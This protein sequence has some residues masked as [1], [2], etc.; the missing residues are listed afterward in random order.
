MSFDNHFVWG[1]AAASYQIE[2]AGE[3]AGRGDS[4]WDMFSRQ[5]D[6]V[7][8]NQSGAVACDHYHRYAEDVRLMAEL[9]LHAYRYSI[10]WPRVIPN[11]TGPVHAEGLDF[12]DRLTDALLEVGIQ[13]WVTLFHWDYP[14]EL[15]T[16]GGWL[17]PDSPDWFAEYART[18]VHRLSDRV[19]H[20]ITQ[21]EPQA[22]IRWGHQAGVHAPGTN[23][24]E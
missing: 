9:G 19:R 6:R 14:Y 23:E 15:F 8:R 24:Q 3:G 5:P 12:Y 4:V 1:A 7:W 22:Y 18:V 10:S 13:P 2:G 11:G 20:W 21:N 17:N 16:R